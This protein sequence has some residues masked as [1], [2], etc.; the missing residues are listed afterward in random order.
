MVKI[1]QLL[2]I[3]PILVCTVQP[4]YRIQHL[5][6]AISKNQGRRCT[7]SCRPGY[8]TA[9]SWTPQSAIH[10]FRINVEPVLLFGFEV[11]LP[12]GRNLETLEIY[13]RSCLKQ[14][15][16]LPRNTSTPAIYILAG[17]L[18]VQAL[19]HKRALSLFGNVCRLPETAVEKQLTPS[20]LGRRQFV[21]LY[22]H[23][24]SIK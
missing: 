14:L 24:G 10:V 9:T 22:T 8:M 7:G 21:M 17:Y 15:L 23:I 20:L 2:I 12:V 16:T 4:P 13:L 19:I 6:I 11:C 18:P 1:C 3:P 5:L